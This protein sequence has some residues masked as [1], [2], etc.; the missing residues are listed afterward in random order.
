MKKLNRVAH[1]GARSAWLWRH[2]EGF[3][4]ARS[5]HMPRLLV[6]VS[7][8]IRHD[9]QTGIQR[10]VRSV[11]SELRRRNGISFDVLPVFATATHGYCYAQPDFLDRTDS[12]EMLEPVRVREGDKFIGLDLAAHLLPKYRQQL[13]AWR[14]HGAKVHLVVYDLL[15]MQRP[16]WFTPSS[17]VNFGRWF[18]VLANEADQAICISDQVARDL[19]AQLCSMGKTARPAISRMQMGANIAGSVPSSGVCDALRQTL[20]QIRFRPAIL[21]VGTVEPRKGYDTALAAFDHLWKTRPDS[22]DLILVGKAGWK[23]KAVQRSIT[24]HKEF[25]RRLHWFNALSDEG[26]C[27]LY[28]ACRGLLMA[29]RGEGWGLPLIEAAMHRRHV[30]ARDLPVFREQGLSNIVYFRDDSPEALGARL[31]E[32]VQLGQAPHSAASL[33]TW[34]ECVDGLLQVLGMPSVEATTAEPLL[35]AS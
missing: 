20:E 16:E 8:I 9:A 29:S 18:D 23:T 31:M 22:P 14:S 1:L 35:K 19:D 34:S 21:M 2:R 27:L 5:D 28:D 7:A 10:V 13:R 3:R 30:L 26:L 12:R 6:D 25:G 24:S 33:P 15:P 32:L 11:W 17:A 4:D